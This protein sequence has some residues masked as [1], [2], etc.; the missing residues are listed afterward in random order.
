MA[1]IPDERVFEYLQQ[2]VP[3]RY[4]CLFKDSISYWDCRQQVFMDLRIENKRLAGA[5]RRYLSVSNARCD[6]PHEVN[7]LARRQNWE[8]WVD[9]PV[10]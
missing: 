8:A 4:F 1:G 2:Y 10:R 3:I 9:L 6:T 7:I 5:C